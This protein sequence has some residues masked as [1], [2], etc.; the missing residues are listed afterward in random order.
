[1]ISVIIPTHNYGKYL[2]QCLRS[3]KNQTKKVDEIIVVDDASADNTSEVVERWR[4]VKY[5]R[6]NFHQADRSRNFGFRKSAG[7]YIMFFDGDDYLR[8]DAIEKLYDALQKNRQ[9]AFAYSDRKDLIIKNGK[10]I[11]WERF[12]ALPWNYERLKYDNFVASWGLIKRR[13]FVRFDE[14]LHRL[15]DWELWLSIGKKAPGIYVPHMLTIKRVHLHGI[16]GSG[17]DKLLSADDY[18]R[19]KHQLLP[20]PFSRKLRIRLGYIKKALLGEV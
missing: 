2:A 10:V 3:I 5:F 12:K 6:V 11:R 14:K 17:P 19:R 13:S 20:M 1:M 18:V 4:S 16:T 15:Q 8:R 9:A 7:D